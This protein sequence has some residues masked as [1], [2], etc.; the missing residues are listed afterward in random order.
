[1]FRPPILP[2]ALKLPGLHTTDMSVLSFSVP[3]NIS[4]PG[5]SHQNSTK[6]PPEREEKNEFCGGRGKKSEILG[7]PGGGE[8]SK[9]G[10]LGEGVLRWGLVPFIPN[11][12][13]PN[14]S[15]PFG[16]SFFSDETILKKN[17][18]ETFWDETVIPRILSSPSSP[19]QVALPPYQ[20]TVEPHLAVRGQNLEVG[21]PSSS[22]SLG[23]E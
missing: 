9:A 2:A 23:G 19:H 12:V 3:K 11:F 4:G 20:G 5:S 14:C 8:G 6:R 1:M 21:H 17:Q 16:R 18:D 7:G 13:G 15:D 10:G 22:K